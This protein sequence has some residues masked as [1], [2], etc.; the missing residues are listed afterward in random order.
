MEK[1]K[2][3][4]G[5]RLVKNGFVRG[6]QRYRCQHCGKNQIMGDRREKHDNAVRRKA[7]AMHLDSHGIRRI[8]RALK[9][10]HQLVAK[11][12][13]DPDGII[14]RE[15]RNLHMVPRTIGMLEMDKLLAYARKNSAKHAYGWLWIGNEMK[16]LRLGKTSV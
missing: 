16:L 12:V 1:C 9:V 2:T 10:P 14:A 8:G 15:I 4:F 5:E 7:L 11:W 6:Q 13:E 3:C